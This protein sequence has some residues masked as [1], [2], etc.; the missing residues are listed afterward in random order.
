M[1]KTTCFVEAIWDVFSKPKKNRSRTFNCCLKKLYSFKNKAELKQ[2]KKQQVL[3]VDYIKHSS[4]TSEKANS[5][6]HKKKIFLFVPY[7]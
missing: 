6:G 5:L 3:A 2:Y 4:Q 1:A 7:I